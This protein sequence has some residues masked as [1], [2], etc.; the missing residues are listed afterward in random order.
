MSPNTRQRQEK[1]LTV[2]QKQIDREIMKFKIK[3]THGTPMS[4]IEDK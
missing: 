3:T 2:A 4:E 1:S